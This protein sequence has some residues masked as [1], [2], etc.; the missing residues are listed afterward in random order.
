MTDLQT[1]L[2]VIG[3]AIVVGVMAF[4]KWQE[5]KAKKS[6]ERAFSTG[7]DDVLM[8]PSSSSVSSSNE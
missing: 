5:H 3:G 1:S 7:Q 2:I 4:N 8:T 6:V